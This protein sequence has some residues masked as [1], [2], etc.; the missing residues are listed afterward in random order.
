MDLLTC[1]F[2][3]CSYACSSCVYSLI[4]IRLDLCS[5]SFCVSSFIV[6]TFDMCYSNLT[7]SRSNVFW[8]L[9][10]FFLTHI[11]CRFLWMTWES[12]YLVNLTCWGNGNDLT[13]DYSYT[14]LEPCELVIVLVGMQPRQN[15]GEFGNVT[16]FN[17]LI[18]RSNKT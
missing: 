2:D 3:S 7:T 4:I 8:C 9:L 13:K 6:V 10:N 5:R 18:S 12:R 1:T 16:S 14:C 17:M 11:F 15:W